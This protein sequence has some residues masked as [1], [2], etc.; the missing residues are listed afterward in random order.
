MFK[1]P[2]KLVDGILLIPA[3]ANGKEGFFAFDTGAM[4]TA[5]N[6]A[7]FPELQGEQ[8]N[9]AK[10]SE[11]VKETVADQG[12]LDNLRVPGIERTNMPVLIMDLMYVENA[13]TPSMP[14]L[15]FLGTLGIDVISK[16]TVL[17]DYN[18]S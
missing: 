6:K 13:L 15:M 16:Y 11:E 1:L 14:D 12:V 3:A 10:F 17:L 7:H 5:V 9:I 8:I 2:Y 4:Q 18:H